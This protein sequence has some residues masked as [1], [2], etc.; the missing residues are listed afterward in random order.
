M[1]ELA[2]M[3][4]TVG[5]PGMVGEDRFPARTLTVRALC[6]LI[7]DVEGLRVFFVSKRKSVLSLPPVANSLLSTDYARPHIC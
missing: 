6:A 5:W 3:D 1:A 4:V 7:K 2:E